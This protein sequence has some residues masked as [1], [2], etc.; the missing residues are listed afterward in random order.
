MGQS[1]PL[2]HRVI[3]F[4]G[5]TPMER[6]S[7]DEGRQKMTFRYPIRRDVLKT[8]T[9]FLT[10]SMSAKRLGLSAA[11]RVPEKIVLGAQP[12]TPFIESYLGATDFFKEEGLTVEVSR[13]NSFAPVLQ[14]LA[15]GNLAVGGMGVAPS[16]IGISRGLPIIAP[17]LVTFVTP[18]RPLERI[19]VMPNSPIR[20]INDLQGKK[21]AFLGPGTV[22]D[23][24]LDALP[25]KS[26]IRKDEIQLV[27]MPP[28]SM[29]DALAQGL[30]DA[31][32]AIPPGD[33]VA[34][35]KYNARTVVNATELVPY[36]GLN[37]VA[38]RR[39]FA[40]TNP[41]ATKRLL[42][43]Y[44]RLSRW[45][46][47]NETEA[48]KAMGENLGLPD[49][50]AARARIPLFSRNCLPVMPNVWNLYE[51]LVRNKTIDAHPE[52]A[53]LFD[54]A[55]VEPTKR[56]TLPVA[57]SLG[58]QPDPDIEAMLKGDYG[59]LPKLVPSYY[60]DWERHQLKI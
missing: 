21:L 31:I 25:M 58:L 55:I 38:F 17:S 34:E 41:D 14:A 47:D 23:M 8:A 48:R 43:A 51:M 46:G 19:M 35:T 30:V 3:L 27:P 11:A 18:R 49:S 36:A 12:I 40:E 28:P 60:A 9:A 24:M 32:F 26:S 6:K 52:P 56:F 2:R 59:F 53:K 22:P 54:A 5:L 37:T 13:F 45:V 39:E 50:L 16:I 44:I 15:A 20:T 7:G 1:R 42:R 57:E 4:P 10:V 33:T 29:P